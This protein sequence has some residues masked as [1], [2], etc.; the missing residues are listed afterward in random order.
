[1]N[2]GRDDW[3]DH[4]KGLGILLV[5]YGHV[6]RGL[7]SAGLFPDEGLFS[8]LDNFVYLIHMPVFF[9]LSGCFFWA[10]Y[11]KRGNL[12]ISDKIDKILVPYV[13]WSLLQ[14]LIHVSMVSQTNQA[15]TWADVLNLATPRAQFWFLQSLFAMF[16]VCFLL[17]RVGGEKRL[18]W[19]LVIAGAALLYCTNP[20][21]GFAG[22]FSP[23]LVF[24]V[25][26][27]FFSFYTKKLKSV[28]AASIHGQF[29]FLFSL[30]A[31]YWAVLEDGFNFA[32]RGIHTLALSF[33]AVV[34]VLFFSTSIAG[35]VAAFFA[36]LGRKSFDIFL[37]HIIFG[38]GVRVV[39]QKYFDVQDFYLHLVFGL[40]FGVFGAILAANAM[41]RSRLGFMFGPT[42][43]N[44]MTK[45]MKNT[46]PA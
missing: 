11:R 42:W 16:F 33:L 7:Q 38:S 6:A 43:F 27:V 37:L 30:A 12:F 10:A 13:L 21:E 44:D 34:G 29:V 41:R 15:A 39:M 36:Y 2:Q 20:Q 28:F 3:A 26:G 23:F 25:L 18:F 35:R 31:L 14:G 1:M 46:R 17:A 9:F 24:F 8:L 32:D 5:V 22:N 40:C 45:A 19:L 4:A